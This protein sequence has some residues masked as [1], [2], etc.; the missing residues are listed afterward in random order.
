[1]GRYTIRR[2]G[3]LEGCIRMNGRSM[4]TGIRSGITQNLGIVM[5][6]GRDFIVGY[7]RSRDMKGGRSY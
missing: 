4:T 3:M 1:M 2:R 5:I 7:T 6:H